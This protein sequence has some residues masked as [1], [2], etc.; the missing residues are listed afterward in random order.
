VS[1][2]VRASGQD[3]AE[4]SRKLR[5]AGNKG[6]ARQFRTELRAAAAPFVPAVRA[7][8]AA[9]P[10]KGTSGST[11]LRQRLS[12]AV[13]LRVRTSGKNA[14]VS[15]LMSTAKMPSGQRSL[16]AM[17]EGTKRWRHP[18]FGNEDV[19]VSQ[20]SHPYFFKVVRAGGPAAKAAVNKVVGNIT[21]EIT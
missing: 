9:I 20:E 10:V 6:A 17:M 12:K 2:S 21:R 13:T 19:W 3:L 16:P 4:V 14:Q 15:I 8:I 18:V 5:K 1:I 7:S 11:G